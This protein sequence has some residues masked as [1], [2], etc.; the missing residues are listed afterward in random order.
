MFSQLLAY[1]RAFD[2]HDAQRLFSQHWEIPITAVVLYVALVFYG[3]RLLHHRKPLNVRGFA[4]AWNVSIALFSACGAAVCVPHLARQLWARGFWF[5]ACGDVY[6]LAGYGVPAFWASLFTWSKLLELVDTAL[7]VAS[8]RPVI[9]L[10]WFH[11][12]SVILFAWAAWAYETPCALWY[13]AMNYAVHA[14]M[15]AYFAAMGSRW[16]PVVRKL[17]PL[18]TA[19][20]IAQFAFGTFVNAFAAWHY[21]AG[22]YAGDAAGV[23]CSIQ[24]PILH[25][26][27]ALYLAYGA[28]FCQLFYR[29]YLAS[30]DPA[31]AR[32]RTPARR[33]LGVVPPGSPPR[34]PP[35]SRPLR[36]GRTQ[37]PVSRFSPL[38]G[39]GSKRD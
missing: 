19:L 36:S 15:Y 32:T 26:S 4:F 16:R 35:R 6:E 28:L 13:G 8:K 39:G 21:A 2:G 10:H 3:P 24:L 34:S 11:H 7:L 31:G 30:Q 22:T 27:L 14:L 33:K 29:R 17:A 25:L 38:R 20:Q 18:I 23:G 12:A 9:T 5:T 37:K 1:Q